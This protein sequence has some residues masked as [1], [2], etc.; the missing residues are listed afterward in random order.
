MRNLKAITKK[1]IE[2]HAAKVSHISDFIDKILSESGDVTAASIRE[3]NV[4]KEKTKTFDSDLGEAG[5]VLR[6]LGVLVPLVLAFARQ[7]PQLHKRRQQLLAQVRDLHERVVAQ[8]VLAAPA[9]SLAL[10][11]RAPRLVNLE[12]R[13]VVR[14]PH[15]K[16]LVRLAALF[17]LVRRR[18][19]R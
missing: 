11:H 1:N 6:V 12:E 16:L 5:E 18:E 4:S 19:Q 2:L 17:A 14:V 10:G 9:P 8:E 15:E 13:E 3:E 7:K